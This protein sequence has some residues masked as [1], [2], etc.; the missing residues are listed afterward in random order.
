MNYRLEIVLNNNY[1]F[2]KN[3]NFDRANMIIFNLEKKHPILSL[4]CRDYQNSID[5][6][7]YDNDVLVLN[8][9]NIIIHEKE[10]YQIYTLG[11]KT[12][13]CHCIEYSDFVIAVDIK[14]YFGMKYFK[15]IFIFKK[16]II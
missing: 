1:K 6:A 7:I 14:E 13:Y 4:I 16:K 11:N 10:L 15:S 12:L 3:F 9:K 2:I 8:K 5:I